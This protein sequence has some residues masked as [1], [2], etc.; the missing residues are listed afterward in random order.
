MWFKKNKYNDE[1]ETVKNSN[2]F[3][4]VWYLN[5]NPDVKNDVMDPAEHYIKYGWREGRAASAKFS[6][7]C[8]I[9]NN[10]IDPDTIL[11]DPIYDYIKNSNRNKKNTKIYSF[12]YE[13][14][15]ESPLFDSEWYLSVNNDVR[16]ANL[17]PIKHYME[18]GWKGVRNPSIHFDSS[19]YLEQYPSVKANKLNPLLHYETEGRFIG[20]KYS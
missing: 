3:D 10:D 1:Y 4:K 9:K 16:K 19:Y 15:S 17:D 7:K 2:F 13:I 6:T 11:F 5:N 14:I 20:C 8:Y 18:W 12:A